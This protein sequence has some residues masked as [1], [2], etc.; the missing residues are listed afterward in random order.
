MIYI[1]LSCYWQCKQVILGINNIFCQY[2]NWCPCENLLIFWW[3]TVDIF[4]LWLYYSEFHSW[5]KI[6]LLHGKCWQTSFSSVSKVD[7]LTS[8]HISLHISYRRQYDYQFRAILTSLSGLI[9]VIHGWV[10]FDKVWDR[11]G[12]YSALL[13]P[14]IITFTFD[15]T[16]LLFLP[17]Q[18]KTVN[19]NTRTSHIMHGQI[20]LNSVCCLAT[21]LIKSQW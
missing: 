2:V 15:C 14:P 18:W 12:L 17:A 20:Q 19:N 1:F 10:G 4:Q 21:S 9:S 11:P 8:D 13:L 7:K 16:A 5:N 3:K 6:D